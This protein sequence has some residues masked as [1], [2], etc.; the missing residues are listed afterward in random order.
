MTG[1]GKV[2]CVMDER[3]LQ[4]Q[5]RKKQG[6]HPAWFLEWKSH[7]IFFPEEV[8]W[9]NKKV[10]SPPGRIGGGKSK[11]WILWMHCCDKRS[12]WVKGD[13]LGQ[14]YRISASLGQLLT[15]SCSSLEVTIPLSLPLCQ[16]VLSHHQDLHGPPVRGH[17]LLMTRRKG[18]S[19]VSLRQWRRHTKTS[20]WLPG[21]D[22]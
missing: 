13:S 19:V 14:F 11:L 7:L 9:E 5:L 1:R 22:L 20:R 15:P 4:A 18:G 10:A 12:T 2:V 21:L 6:G 8:S 16:R 3:T 17:A